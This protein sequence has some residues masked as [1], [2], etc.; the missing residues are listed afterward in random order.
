MAIAP[1]TVTPDVR[2]LIDRVQI[3]RARLEQAQ[4]ARTQASVLAER[5][6]TDAVDAERV[7]T[8]TIQAERVQ[9][10]RALEGAQIDRVD[11]SPGA[12]SSG[13]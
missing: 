3:E 1:V 6:R 12:T 4:L 13:R 5:L 8:E 9:T 11:L 2:A 10:E 7:R